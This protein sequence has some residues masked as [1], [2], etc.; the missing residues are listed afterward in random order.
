MLPFCCYHPIDLQ[1]V[2]EALGNLPESIKQATA[3]LI[4]KMNPTCNV[5]QMFRYNS[6]PWGKSIHAVS[7]YCNALSKYWTFMNFNLF[8][9]VPI[10]TAAYIWIFS[11]GQLKDIKADLELNDISVDGGGG[12]RLPCR[13]FATNTLRVPPVAGV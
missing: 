12:E 6:A 8:E 7:G 13:A 2:I 11:E 3:A 5:T 1:R 4:A 10:T 9:E